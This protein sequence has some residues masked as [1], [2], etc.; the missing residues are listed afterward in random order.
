M[1][2]LC[3][4]SYNT[5]P[6]LQRLVNTLHVGDHQ[7]AYRLYIA[8]NGSTDGSV[9]W[10]K[11]NFDLSFGTIHFNENV[12][13]A[14]ACNQLAALG[15]SE[16]IGLL[17]ADVW[18]D[19]EDVAVIEQCFHETDADILGP[20]QR[21]EQGI[22]RHAGI[23]GTNTAPKHR[24]WRV[25]DPHDHFFRDRLEA[26]TVSGSAYFV[27]RSVWDA[28]TECPVYRSQEVTS[29]AVGAF[30]PTPHYY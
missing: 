10:L 19:S 4:V 8:D 30:L 1:I 12:G 3:V 5:L 26:V 23:F 20:K 27:R 7:D 21:D 17:N 9:G 13:Y 11:D 25:R 16:F 28:L 6:L 2:D 15:N 18:L 29:S 24:G 22:V 14:A